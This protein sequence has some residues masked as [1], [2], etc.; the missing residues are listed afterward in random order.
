M[1]VRTQIGSDLII[2]CF[3]QQDERAARQ[4]LRRLQMTSRGELIFLDRNFERIGTAAISASNDE[5]K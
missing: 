1:K 2:D 3:D 5:E 4:W